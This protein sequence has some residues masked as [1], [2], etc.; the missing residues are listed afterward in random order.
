MEW[1][2]AW[3]D[4]YGA[5]ATLISA[6]VIG[7]LMLRRSSRDDNRNDFIDQQRKNFE[8]MLSPL[9]DEVAELRGRVTTLE[10]EVR[11]ERDLRERIVAFTRTLLWTWRRKYPDDPHPIPPDSIS[12]FF[13]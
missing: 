2:S 6:A 13:D 5:V 8:T 7:P 9:R 3:V 10:A 12:T 4:E 1:L 11:N